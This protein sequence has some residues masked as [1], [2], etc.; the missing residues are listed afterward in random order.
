MMVILMRDEDSD[1]RVLMMVELIMMTMIITIHGD[2]SGVDDDSCDIDGGDHDDAG[3]RW[4]G[5][6][7]WGGELP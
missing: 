6:W 5:G 7:E 4:M 3:G 2:D 1:L